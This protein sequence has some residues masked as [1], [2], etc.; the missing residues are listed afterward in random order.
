[1]D[2]QN[3]F[4]KQLSWESRRVP[5]PPK[6][7]GEPLGAAAPGSDVP[8]GRA[9]GRT[10]EAPQYA[11][12]ANIK[13]KPPLTQEP[14]PSFR[15]AASMTAFILAILSDSSDGPLDAS[16]SAVNN[17]PKSMCCTTGF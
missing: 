8:A 16:Q 5:S 10:A 12:E 11:A 2:G 7:Q 9:G 15:F 1:M 6:R 4:P 14:I 3:G 17:S 13:Q